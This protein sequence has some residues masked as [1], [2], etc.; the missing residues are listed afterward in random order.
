MP[1]PSPDG[2]LHVPTPPSD[3][4]P[5][6]TPQ[7][8]APQITVNIIQNG[9]GTMN[10]G[11][12]SIVLSPAER[13][14]RILSP[15]ATVEHVATTPT[16]VASAR[17]SLTFPINPG[18]ET[19]V[20]V[21]D[22]DITDFSATTSEPKPNVFQTMMSRG[23]GKAVNGKSGSGKTGFKRDSGE[24]SKC[25]EC[26]SIL[27]TSRMAQ[28]RDTTECIKR[29]RK[30]RLSADP[31]AGDDPITAGPGQVGLATLV[32]HKAKRQSY[33]IKFKMKVINSYDDLQSIEQQFGSEG[34]KYS[35]VD[36]I[37]E[38]YN[39]SNSMVNKWCKRD[40]VGSQRASIEAAHADT[41]KWNHEKV[42][43]STYAFKAVDDR[44]IAWY[45]ELR[46]KGYPVTPSMMK[47]RF[48][49]EF[50]KDYPMQAKNFIGSDRWWTLF[51]RRNR[52][53]Y[54]KKTNNHHLTWEQRLLKYQGFLAGTMKAHE[55]S[56]RPG[57]SSSNGQYPSR[58]E[59]SNIDQ[60]PMEYGTHGKATMADTNSDVVTIVVGQN[61]DAH[62]KRCCTFQCHIKNIPK[63]KGHYFDKDGKWCSR[64][65]PPTIVFPGKG[66]SYFDKERK[67]YHPGV[68][69]MYQKKAWMDA[70]QCEL[71]ARWYA[72][73]RKKNVKS[74]GR[75]LL[76]MDNLHGQ[77]TEIFKKIM[78][79]AWVDIRYGPS[80]MTDDW[81]REFTCT[82]Y[83]QHTPFSA[84]TAIQPTATNTRTVQYS[85]VL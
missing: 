30:R 34:V 69:V 28:H 75:E 39:I 7:H 15:V 11:N 10:V 8:A 53:S 6:S 9:S 20:N 35:K 72:A 85:T 1:S 49:V 37:S 58:S 29:Q 54:R 21:V 81:Q 61:G 45:K 16:S 71:Y 51:K 36:V 78:N 12:T 5:P 57:F 48:R 70:D 26:E 77:K 43:R 83:R 38:Q 22:F 27:L 32:K 40:V 31:D 17:S 74:P 4:S 60:V 47:S 82:S 62:L 79:D 23:T 65:P 19:V 66:G 44:V 24:K 52:I 2:T 80:N 14:T 33:P 73:W 50:T 41:N 56:K 18:R 64:H 76:F 3:R 55:N 59:I 67:D 42:R 68:H 13:S 63:G 84:C 46:D 25:D